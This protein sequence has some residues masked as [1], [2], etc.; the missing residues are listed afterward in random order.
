[1]DG[2]RPLDEA[3]QRHAALRAIR[4]QVEDPQRVIGHVRLLAHQR[5]ML[6]ADRNDFAG[7]PLGASI[8]VGLAW[9]DCERRLTHWGTN[10]NVAVCGG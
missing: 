4:Q 5:A 1:M 2:V 9:P 6:W 7:R 3:G 10:G 8:R